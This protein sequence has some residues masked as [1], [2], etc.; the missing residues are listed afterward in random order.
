MYPIGVV[1]ATFIVC[2]NEDGM[3]LVDQHA[4][5]ERINYEYFLK[6]ISNPKREYQDLLVPIE[7]ELTS[8]EYLILTDHFH[9]I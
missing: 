1:H 7:I 5:A 3:Y 9:Q 6:E 4:A 2:E 8:N